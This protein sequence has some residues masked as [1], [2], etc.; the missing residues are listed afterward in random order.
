MNVPSKYGHP[1]FFTDFPEARITWLA[2]AFIALVSPW[3]NPPNRLLAA[4]RLQR[5]LRLLPAGVVVALPLRRH[6]L[7]KTRLGALLLGGL[8]PGSSSLSLS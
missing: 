5:R 2:M 1:P 7:R 4:H 3:A 6:L 8:E